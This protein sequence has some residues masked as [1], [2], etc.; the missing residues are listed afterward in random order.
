MKINQENILHLER[1]FLFRVVLTSRTKF[2]SVLSCCVDLSNQVDVGYIM[3]C[4]S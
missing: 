2:F 3:L 1:L 4:G